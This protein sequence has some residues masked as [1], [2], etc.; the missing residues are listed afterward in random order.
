MI[1]LANKQLTMRILK[2]IVISLILTLTLQN[3]TAQQNHIV[4][5]E[6]VPYKQ[7]HHVSTSFP[8]QWLQTKWE[9]KYTL[10]LASNKK[11]EWFLVM[12]KRPN[13]VQQR[14]MIDPSNQQILDKLT[15]GY[16]IQ[17]LTQ[18]PDGKRIKNFFLFTKISNQK[19]FNKYYAGFEDASENLKTKVQK[20]INKGW[21]CKSISS[22]RVNCF[23]EQTFLMPKSGSQYNQIVDYRADWPNDYINNK[24]SQGYRLSAVTYDY[25]EKSW[26][27]VMHKRKPSS[28][29]WGNIKSDWYWFNYKAQ[30][31]EFKDKLNSGF[32][33]VGVF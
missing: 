18:Y 4:I 10:T 8:K 6:P 22:M 20:L 33:I 1:N 31:Q 13:E 27:V 26:L 5:M 9:E 3:V 16:M 19:V 24:R 23:N 28:N 12:E 29:G 30:M 17:A 7:V 25:D 32:G 11:G 2:F 21:Y 15:D 14:Y